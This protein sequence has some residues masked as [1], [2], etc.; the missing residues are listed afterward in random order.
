M[1]GEEDS[2]LFSPFIVY[3]QFV[4]VYFCFILQC[5]LQNIKY[6]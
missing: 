2:Q 3:K 5:I 1:K 4:I 6:W